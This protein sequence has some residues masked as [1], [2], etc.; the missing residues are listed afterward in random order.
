M[1]SPHPRPIFYLCPKPPPDPSTAPPMRLYSALSGNPGQNCLEVQLTKLV[2]MSEAAGVRLPI[3]IDTD[4]AA[5]ATTHRTTLIDLGPSHQSQHPASVL[6][7][8]IP[9]GLDSVSAPLL[10]PVPMRQGFSSSDEAC[11]GEA[12]RPFRIGHPPPQSLYSPAE[13]SKPCQ[14]ASYGCVGPA[15]TIHLCPPC[16]SSI[17]ISGPHCHAS[18]CSADP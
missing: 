6:G 17:T 5:P 9:E 7:T 10:K 12:R 2:W 16:L 1:I 11:P 3:G 13:S 4:L 8:K 15:D 18:T 14:R